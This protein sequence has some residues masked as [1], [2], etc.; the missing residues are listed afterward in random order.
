VCF[1]KTPK[2]QTPPPAPVTDVA[3]EAATNAASDRMSERR[4][5]MFALSR[6]K[7]AEGGAMQG[8][9][10]ANNKWKLGG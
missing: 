6:Q 7:T 2:V 3:G 4:R 10:A 5:K 8:P 1:A 9:D